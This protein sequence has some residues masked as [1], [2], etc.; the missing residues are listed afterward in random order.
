ML[1]VLQ[2]DTGLLSFRAELEAMTLPE[3]KLR[4]VIEQEPG[5]LFSSDPICVARK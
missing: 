5:V 4:L 3:I 1:R 2:R